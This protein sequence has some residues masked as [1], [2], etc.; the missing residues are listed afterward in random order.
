M[1]GIFPRNYTGEFLIEAP[2]IKS[3]DIDV[4]GG[5]LPKIRVKRDNDSQIYV[6]RVVFNG[7]YL[8]SY[9]I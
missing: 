3:T 9:K 8:P 1:F 4:S 2:Q 6:D 7:E 5:K